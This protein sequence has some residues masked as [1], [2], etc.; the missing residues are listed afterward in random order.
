MDDCCTPGRKPDLKA[1]LAGVLRKTLWLG[2]AA[3]VL[4]GLGWLAS[5]F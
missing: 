3:G 1:R 5:R 2:G 4:L